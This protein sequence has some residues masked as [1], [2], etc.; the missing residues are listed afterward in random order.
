MSRTKTPLIASLLFFFLCT[1]VV[2]DGSFT[3]SYDDGSNDA[4][5]TNVYW[6]DTLT[7]NKDAITE[8]NTPYNGIIIY[9][10]VNDTKL[11]LF[12]PNYTG[13][14]TYALKGTKRMDYATHSNA[15]FTTGTSG[16]Y[17]VA[18]D[19][20]TPSSVSILKDENGIITGTYDVAV[21]Y[22]GRAEYIGLKKKP[23]LL[24][25]AFEGVTKKNDK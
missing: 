15:V 18:P 5:T 2:A 22:Y 10:R 24:Q 14:G 7:L 8:S 6:T 23:L 11:M 12:L 17:W 19:D 21:Y 1:S 16:T 13:V 4:D 25:G 3:L 9:S 20:T